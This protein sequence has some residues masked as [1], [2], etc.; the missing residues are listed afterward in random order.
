MTYGDTSLVELVLNHQYNLYDDTGA[1]LEE[2]EDS[3]E[4]IRDPS[5]KPWWKED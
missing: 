2:I 1:T 4:P 5:K 3:T